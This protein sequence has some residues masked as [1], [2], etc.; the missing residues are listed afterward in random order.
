MKENFP[1]LVKEIDMEVQEAQRVSNQMDA[2]RPTP[3][4]IIIKTPKVKDKERLLKA[5]EKK[6]VTGRLPDG[7][8]EGENR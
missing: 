8:G 7:K 6:L 5:R 2:K 3:R 4:H 1:N